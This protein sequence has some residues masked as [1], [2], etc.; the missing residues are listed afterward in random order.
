MVISG[1]AFRHR[2]CI[3]SGVPSVCGMRRR[4]NFLERGYVMTRL[5][6]LGRGLVLATAALIGSASTATAAPML[7]SLEGDTYSNLS[8]SVLFSY[9]G[10]TGSTGRVDVAVTNT[11]SHWDPRLTSFAFNLPG[12][13]G[14]VSSF[15]SSLSGWQSSYDRNDIN[16]PG[17][18]GFYDVAGL[19]GPNFNG[20]APNRGIARGNTATF[21]FNLSGAGML[22]LTESSFLSLLSYD[23]AG[24]PNE[25]EQYFIGRFQRVGLFGQGSDVATPTG[26]PSTPPTRGVPEP[27]TLMLSGLGL[28][29]LTAMRRAKA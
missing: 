20:G 11:S 9:V 12:A 19:S 13:I 8:A 26:A 29:G 10:L 3:V 24:G 4:L 23:P 27:T 1:R 17:Q 28:L 25:A 21:S 15:S 16:T 22:G 18:F 5:G 6:H 14:G 7:F 2:T